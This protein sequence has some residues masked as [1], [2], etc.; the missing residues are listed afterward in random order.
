M[1]T[2]A[3][4][5]P[6]STRRLQ[7]PRPPSWRRRSARGCCRENPAA[8]ERDIEQAIIEEL[9]AFLVETGKGFCSVAR[10][11]RLTLEG[12]LL[13]IDVVFYDRLLRCFLLVDPKMGKRVHE[14][15]GQT[16]MSGD[17]LDRFQRDAQ[18]VKERAS[19]AA[20]TGQSGDFVMKVLGR[21]VGR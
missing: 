3:S 4:L 15:L 18:E 14:D 1:S 10:H 19:H 16:R 5:P 17:F 12:P 2:R 21:E 20:A 13:Y 8:Q 11:K 7:A 9:G 6:A